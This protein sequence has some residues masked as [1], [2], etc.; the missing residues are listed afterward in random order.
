MQD[1]AERLAKPPK[2]SPY[3]FPCMVLF[4]FHLNPD[5]YQGRRSGPKSV[6]VCV[7]GGGGGGGGAEAGGR[8]EWGGR[9]V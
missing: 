8:D 4:S 9:C 2:R 6:C 1:A 5:Y 7:C 3:S